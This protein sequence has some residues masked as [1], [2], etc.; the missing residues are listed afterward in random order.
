M[1]LFAFLF[2]CSETIGISFTNI[3]CSD[4][5]CGCAY[6]NDVA[7]ISLNLVPMT[8]ETQAS[9]LA[10]IAFYVGQYTGGACTVA[11][12]TTILNSYRATKYTPYHYLGWNND[13]YSY[14]EIPLQQTVLNKT[15]L[16][17]WTDRTVWHGPGLCLEDLPVVIQAAFAA[18]GENVTATFHR[19]NENDNLT[20]QRTEFVNVINQTLQ[21]PLQRLLINFDQ[22]IV[23]DSGSGC[24]HVSPVVGWDPVNQLVLIQDVWRYDYEPYWAP[25]DRVIQAITTITNQ[26]DCQIQ[27]P[28]LAAR[29]YVVVAPLDNSVPLVPDYSAYLAADVKPISTNNIVL[30]SSSIV[31]YWAQLPYYQGQINPNASSVGAV[32]SILNSYRHAQA[33]VWEYL[34]TFSDGFSYG[35]NVHPQTV[36]SLANLSW[37]TNYTAQIC[38]Q[39]LPVVIEAAFAGVGAKVHATYYRFNQSQSRTQQK[40]QLITAIQDALSSS[41]NRLILDFDRCIALNESSIVPCGHMSPVAG[42]DTVN[43]LVLV[44]DVYRYDYQPY[45]IPTNQLLAALVAPPSETN[46]QIADPNA[47]VSRGYVTVHTTQ[48]SCQNGVAV[49]SSDCMVDGAESCLSCN[50]N[51]HL[52]GSMGAQVCVATQ[53]SCQNGVAVASSDCMVDGAESC[54][55]CNPNYHLLGSMGA[56]VCVA[57]PVTALTNFFASCTSSDINV[58]CRVPCKAAATL[59]TSASF[60]GTAAINQTVIANMCLDFYN[61]VTIGNM[62]NVGNM[63]TGNSAV[64][65]DAT[66]L[67]AIKAALSGGAPLCLATV[68]TSAASGTTLLVSM[69]A[70]GL[71]VFQF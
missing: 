1:K 41:T 15:G 64:Q 26:S 10:N 54:L 18:F 59:L 24:G 30:P 32:T 65:F 31:S 2:L 42:L 11:A 48:C 17:W 71:S 47:N 40:N 13:G 23:L 16:Q 35:Q 57:C 5:S 45:W 50:P 22:C 34:P 21:N 55:S 58:A 4:Y 44:L 51:Y 68:S 19:F 46:C 7:P 66:A 43:D 36:L 37:W 67:K 69:L 60:N 29:G 56:Q 20:V 27:A 62:S 9:F 53:C 39:D 70:I 52:L 61:N 25:V 8:P 33:G 3:S 28:G 38:L 12:V 63:S 14:G 6:P 49:A